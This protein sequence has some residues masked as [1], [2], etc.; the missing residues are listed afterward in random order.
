MDDDQVIADRIEA[1]TVDPVQSGIGPRHS[2]QFLVED[3]VAE[4]LAGF[5]LGSTHCL[6][7]DQIAAPGGNVSRLWQGC[8][9]PQ[10][11]FA[12]GTRSWKVASV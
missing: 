12:T 9:T 7:Q 2:S 1:V 5:D 10:A 3:P 6:P 8:V 11:V 4:A